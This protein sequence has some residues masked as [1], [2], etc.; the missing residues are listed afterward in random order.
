M[1]T[2]M[3]MH[4]RKRTRGRCGLG[5]RSSQNTAARQRHS[6]SGM[7]VDIASASRQPE[8][9][10][11][12]VC[13]PLVWF[14]ARVVDQSTI[15]TAVSVPIRSLFMSS[16]SRSVERGHD[17]RRKLLS[18]MHRNADAGSDVPSDLSVHVIPVSVN[19]A[20]GYV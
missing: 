5:V 7:Q 13:L 8:S 1:Q 15:K 11:L 16:L 12:Q 10:L 20:S 14:S 17:A 6:Y 19:A 3:L 4:S 18:T 9:A 2:S